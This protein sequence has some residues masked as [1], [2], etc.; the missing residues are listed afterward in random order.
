MPPATRNQKIGEKTKTAGKNHGAESA[1]MGSGL[2]HSMTRRDFLT[3]TAVGSAAVLAGGVGSLVQAKSPFRGLHED[4]PWFEA[5][6]LELQALMASGQIGSRELTKAYL[7]RI[8][9]LN[10]ILHAVIETNPQAVGIAAGLDAERR[11]GRVRGPLHGIPILLKDNIATDDSMQT[12]AGSLALVGSRVPRDATVAAR[13]RAAG[14]VI[15]GKANLSEWAN[16]RGNVPQPVIDLGLFLNG[17]SARGGF[18]RDPYVLTWDPCGSSSGSA[19]GAS[20]NMCAAAVGTETDG[21]VVCPAGNNGIVGLKPTLGL[22]AQN[23]IIPIAHSQDTAGPMARTVTDVAIL[24]NAMKSPFGEVVG[25]TLP[26]DYTTFL[27]RG[28][29]N[30]A[31]IGVDRRLFSAEYFADLT[32]NPITEQALEVMESLGATIVDPVDAPDPFVFSNAEFTVLLFEFKV[33]IAKYLAGLRH[34]SMRTLADL[35][36]FN[37]AHCEQEMKYFG[38]EVF[39][40]AETTTGL[41]D[42]AYVEARALCLEK[43][44]SQGIDKVIADQR[45]DAI[46]APIY[47]FGSSAPAVAGYPNISVPTG[48]TEDGRPGGIWMYGGF[49]QEP[50]LLAF[51]YDLEQ[52]IGGRPKPKFLGSLPPLPPDA[53]ICGSSQQSAIK[54]QA[55]VRRGVPRHL[56]TGKPLIRP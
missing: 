50:K 6:I 55:A 7:S 38:Q 48:V 1:S 24:L 39:D 28:A 8:E 18:T 20:T 34:T 53:G 41:D 3:A 44:R 31:R 37:L 27:R 42:P 26:T 5:T 17:W 32:L 13:L 45:L 56:G 10:P 46:V 4:A 52:E 43:T 29:L 54:N 51:A 15:L 19:V 40:L 14:A 11:S 35:I 47:S 12:T 36:E 16:F 33:D 22:V 30:G 25:H 49:L 23:G 2:P 21:S 9:K